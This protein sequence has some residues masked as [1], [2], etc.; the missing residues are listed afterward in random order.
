V[1]VAASV[2]L[3]GTWRA[4]V[5]G[6]EVTVPAACQRI[7]ALL[8]LS[9]R[10]SRPYLAGTLWGDLDDVRA[11][12][13]LRSTLWRL[14]AAARPLIEVTD[15]ALRLAP[16]VDVDVARVTAMAHALTEGGREVAPDEALAL[17]SG[18]DLLVGW[19]DDWVVPE[20]ERIN[21]LR[22]HALE[23]LADRL[24]AG[25]SG[26]PSRPDLPPSGPIRCARAPIA[27]SSGPTS[28]RAT[29]PRRCASTTATGACST[30]SSGW[31]IPARTWWRWWSPSADAG[32][33]PDARR[34]DC[35]RGP[36]DA[37]SEPIPTGTWLPPSPTFRPTAS[38]SVR[39]GRAGSCTPTARSAAAMT[40]AGSDIY[41]IGGFTWTAG[42]ARQPLA[43]N[44]MYDHSSGTWQTRA[45]M[46]TPRGLAAV[47]VIDGLVYV[48]GGQAPDTTD[49]NQVYDPDADHWAPAAPLPSPRAGMAAGVVESGPYLCGGSCDGEKVL[50]TL[51]MYDPVKD[52]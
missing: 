36:L 9:G 2:T 13:R 10:L 18:P 26:P 33:T 32:G 31:T 22:V 30:A 46:P 15:T 34:R 42:G 28:P 4:T 35:R 40:V 24:T 6:A 11:L 38:A 8:G 43:T 23:A 41:V 44:E 12:R 19:Y 37:M 50:D 7:V 1:D 47:G 14:P 21:Q 3:L 51:Q 49:L 29:R 17:L 27:S 20:R 16:G 48:V 25:T 52:A 45:P 39:R 5:A